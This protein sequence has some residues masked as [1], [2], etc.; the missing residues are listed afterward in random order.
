M[1]IKVRNAGLLY[2]T[3][4]PG[5]AVSLHPRAE[6]T[7]LVISEAIFVFTHPSIGQLIKFFLYIFGGSHPLQRAVGSA[8]VVGMDFNPSDPAIKL[9]QTGEKRKT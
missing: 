4:V 3:P 7:T 9:R 8:D 5:L 1:V 2:V 6:T